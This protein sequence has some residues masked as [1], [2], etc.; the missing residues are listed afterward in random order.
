MAEGK[1]SFIVYTN[2]KQYADEMTDEQL[3]KWHR[4]CLD[5]CNDLDPVMPDD[6]TVKIAILMCKGILERDLAKYKAKA[7]R[8]EKVGK[9][10]NNDT[11]NEEKKKPK[12]ETENGNRKQQPKSV[13]DNSNMLLVNSNKL[14]VDDKSSQINACVCEDEYIQKLKD[15]MHQLE[16]M[17]GRCLTDE[18]RE[19]AREMYD[20]FGYD[21]TMENI[22]KYQETKNPIK[23]AHSVLFNT[24]K[25]IYEAPQEEKI[26]DSGSS[27]LDK[28]EKKEYDNK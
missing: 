17:F 23:Y 2:W 10:Y 1:K 25:T 15:F 19:F 8:F 22:N 7:E 3:G 21:T 16:F 13:C 26:K 27:W 6:P 12:T 14:L 5:F 4:W 24:G 20:K 18:N 9:Q 11:E 28:F